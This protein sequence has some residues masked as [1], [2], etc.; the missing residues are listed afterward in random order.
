MKGYTYYTIGILHIYAKMDRT[1]VQ[2]RVWIRETN[3]AQELIQLI[4]MFLKNK[5]AEI[6]D[7]NSP[8]KL[9]QHP[10]STLYTKNFAIHTAQFKGSLKHVN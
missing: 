4:K 2:F 8:Q 10:S 1:V 3:E 9:H 5:T 6:L 7:F